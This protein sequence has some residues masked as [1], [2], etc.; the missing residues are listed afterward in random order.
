MVLVERN[1]YTKSVHIL[2][3]LLNPYR[4]L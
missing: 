1:T 2:F 3:L 4:G